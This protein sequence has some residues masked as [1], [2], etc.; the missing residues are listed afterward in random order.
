MAMFSSSWLKLPSKVNQPAPAPRSCKSISCSSFRDIQKDQNLCKSQPETEVLSPRSASILQRIKMSTTVLLRL[1][2]R[3]VEGPSGCKVRNGDQRVVIYYTSLRVV[4][5]T[6]EDCRVVRSILG[7]FRVPIDERDLSMDSKF[8]QELEEVTGSKDLN[9][10]MVFVSGDY[11]GG[12]EEVRQLH[13]SGELKT[14]LQGLPVV[15]SKTCDVCGGLRFILCQT[16]NGS[17]KLYR[18]KDGFCPCMDCNMNG[19][20]T[21]PSCSTAGQ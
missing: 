10:P 14:M 8:V 18:Q 11:I 5:R 21:C 20:I 7:G 16:C 1:W 3:G 15:E 2:A 4:R 6:F 13:E 17:H 19:M 9:L 12:A